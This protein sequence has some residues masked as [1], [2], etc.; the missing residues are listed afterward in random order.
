MQL[1]VEVTDN[2]FISDDLVDKIYVDIDSLSL[3]SSFTSYQYY[4]GDYGRSHIELRFRVQCE[5]HYY[6]P[7]CSRYC[8]Y[9]DNQNGHYSCDSDGYKV[10][11]DGWFNSSQNCK[12]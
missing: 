12:G 6:D 4:I 3:S 2:D 1:F 9:T 5:A 11:L 7:D 8:V 10:C